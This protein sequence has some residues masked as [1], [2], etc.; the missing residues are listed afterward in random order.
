[1]G[2]ALLGPEHV[3]MLP[4]PSMGGEDYAFIMEKYPGV[5]IRLGARTPNGPYGSMHSSTFYCDPAAIETGMLTLTGVALD[6]L[7][8]PMEG[9][10][11]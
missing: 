6:Y 7:G 5:F 9:L 10:S 3:V 4:H 8:V 11:S 2:N 1:V